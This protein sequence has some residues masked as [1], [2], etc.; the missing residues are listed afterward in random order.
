MDLY[1]NQRAPLLYQSLTRSMLE[2]DA[3]VVGEMSDHITYLMDKKYVEARV[4]DV[5]L[6]CYKSSLPYDAL[7]R[8]TANG[9]DLIEE[10]IE[11][12]GVLFGDPKR[13]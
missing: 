11:D 9:V 1:K 10:T 8:I 7:I 4:G 13:Q 2:H 3:S 6:D 5:V 12:N